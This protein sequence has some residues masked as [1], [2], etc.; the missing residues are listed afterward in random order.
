MTCSLFVKL[1][2]RSHDM[3]NQ[4]LFTT[5]QWESAKPAS[6]V[7]DHIYYSEQQ[8]GKV[9]VVHGF[10]KTVKRVPSDCGRTQRKVCL[11]KAIWN[12][13]G[14]CRIGRFHVREDRFDI[15]L[16]G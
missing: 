8:P 7:F 9:L 13:D 10:V 3:M 4:V 1:L 15:P 12:A 2:S 16:K 5:K 11:R 6:V 14:Q